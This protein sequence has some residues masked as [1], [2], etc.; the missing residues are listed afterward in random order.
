[1]GLGVQEYHK[2]GCNRRRL[3]RRKIGAG[4]MHIKSEQKKITVLSTLPDSVV[5]FIYAYVF[6]C[7]IY[8]CVW[9]TCV[10]VCVHICLKWQSFE[11]PQRTKELEYLFIILFAILTCRTNY[12]PRVRN[13][14]KKKVISSMDFI[15]ILGIV[16][17][18]NFLTLLFH[19]VVHCFDSTALWIIK[20]SNGFHLLD[21]LF[22]CWNG[23]HQTWISFSWMR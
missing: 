1:M 6:I 2:P 15:F 23:P 5:W 22:S 21:I 10:W 18:F 19:E 14:M 20:S 8:M 17:S 3:H 9:C 7:N 12:N 4:V 16:I 13:M 11:I